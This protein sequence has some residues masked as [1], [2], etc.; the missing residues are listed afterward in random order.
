MASFPAQSQDRRIFGEELLQLDLQLLIGGGNLTQF[1][2]EVFQRDV[3]LL[4]DLEEA[5]EGRVGDPELLSQPL[6][7]LGGDAVGD[8]EMY[9]ALCM[10]AVGVNNVRCPPV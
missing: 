3:L 5:C 2:I 10:E 6:K 7:L 1:R 9:V 4:Q 8:G